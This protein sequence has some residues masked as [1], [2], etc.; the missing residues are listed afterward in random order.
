MGGMSAPAIF[1]AGILMPAR[2]RYP[3]LIERLGSDYDCRPKELEVY[4][5]DEPPPDY[6]IDQEV[7]G[8]L[9]FADDAGL[10]RFHLYGHSGGG[11]VALAFVAV[12]PDRVRSLAVDEPASAFGAEDRAELAA[13]D[14][15][16]E[17]FLRMQ[18]R[19]GV[20][21][22]PRP[23]GEAPPWM[24]KRPAGIAAFAPALVAHRLPEDGYKR[25]EGP[26]Y[27]SYGSLSAERWEEMAGRLGRA[28]RDYRAE[29]YEGL[30]HLNTSHQAEPDRVAERLRD[31]WS[32]S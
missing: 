19:P 2:L 28:F 6:S 17:G 4:A 26:V 8:L 11:A 7:A 12:H 18:L 30:H 27:Y 23:A 13:L 21:L 25:F 14:L 1:L 24:A 29:R 15:D 9:Q 5:G 10:D 16:P 22:P 20:E 32:R 31:L 3:A